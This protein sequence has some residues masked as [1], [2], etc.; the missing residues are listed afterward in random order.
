MKNYQRNVIKM[1]DEKCGL[2]PLSL[3]LKKIALIANRKDSITFITM[4]EYFQNL[5]NVDVDI[6]QD[7]INYRTLI[8][9]SILVLDTYIEKLNNDMLKLCR[10]IFKYKISLVD[11]VIRLNA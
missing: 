9:N 8:Y 3:E 6:M 11:G 10:S 7:A 1:I 4:E 2:K 5:Y